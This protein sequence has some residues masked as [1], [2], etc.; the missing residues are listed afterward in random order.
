VLDLAGSPLPNNLL[1]KGKV[2]DW[3]RAGKVYCGAVLDFEASPDN[4]TF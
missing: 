4:N 2:K 3:A 1:Q